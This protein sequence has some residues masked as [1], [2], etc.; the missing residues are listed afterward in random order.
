MNH[1]VLQRQSPYRT[2]KDAGDKNSLTVCL[3]VS[4]V[5]DQW[6]QQAVWS[7]SPVL[8]PATYPASAQFLRACCHRWRH[9]TTREN[10]R[11]VLP[12][13]TWLLPDVPPSDAD[14]IVTNTIR[15]QTIIITISRNAWQSPAC[16]PP[17]T[18]THAKLAFSV[19]FLYVCWSQ[20]CAM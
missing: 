8:A 12:D 20:V 2:G 15:T 13:C 14:P 3:H 19:A 10:C 6:E 11:H 18:N 9:L 16:S 1:D 17:G 7:A 4:C 5:Q